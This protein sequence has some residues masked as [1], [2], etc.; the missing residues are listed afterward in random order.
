MLSDGGTAQRDMCFGNMGDLEGS[1]QRPSKCLNRTGVER[2][3]NIGSGR[4]GHWL[5]LQST[6]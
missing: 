2:E 4:R 5:L 6:Q 1:M 3:M